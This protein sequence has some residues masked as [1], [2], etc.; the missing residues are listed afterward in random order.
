MV[1]GQAPP[2]TVRN[3]QQLCGA[4]SLGNA[5]R[6][7]CVV[8]VDASES[9]LA[10]ALKDLNTSRATY[11]Q[12]VQDLKSSEEDADAE[13]EEAPFHIQPV[14]ISTRS[15][16]WPWQPAAAGPSFRALW[17]EAKWAP[18]FVLELETQRIAP[19]KQLGNLQDLYQ[20]IAY[21]D[22]K[23]KE[24]PEGLS[25]VRALPDPEAPLR[26]EL[27]ALISSPPAAILLFL[28]VA[29][30]AA[31]LPELSVGAACAALAAAAGLLLSAW[32]WA[33]RRCFA[34]LWC[35]A[36]ASSFECQRNF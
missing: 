35:A 3:H 30:A 32:P 22:L 2:V 8:L 18:A 19:V 14:R 26:R 36:S 6:T 16:R 4:S 24:L 11:S 23:F 33:F 15:S 27:S 9:V 34:L 20:N 29:A 13:A 7:F 25:L 12:E 21:E 28:L 10:G 17:S 1:R 5:M 31:V